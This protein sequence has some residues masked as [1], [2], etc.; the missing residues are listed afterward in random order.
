M[1]FLKLALLATS[2]LLAFGAATPSAHA[3]TFNWSLTGP[4]AALGG[5]SNTGSG[6]LTASLSGGQW[7]ISTITGTVGGSAITGLI[8][9]DGTDNLLFPSTTFLDTNGLGFQTANGTKFDIF[10]FYAPN[11]TDIVPGNNYGEIVSNAAFGVGTFSLAPVA[12]AVPEPGTIA[13]LS[14][15]LLGLSTIRRRRS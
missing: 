13:L 10:S 3:D 6:T 12:A 4:A 1:S 14:T 7:V 2:S 5:F 15:G 9:F 11:S 8:S